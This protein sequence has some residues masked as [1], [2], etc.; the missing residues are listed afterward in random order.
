[1]SANGWVVQFG[2][3]SR[4]HLVC[5]SAPLTISFSGFV[6]SV[7]SVIDFS[8]GKS[9]RYA[10]E[11]WPIIPEFGRFAV[12]RRCRSSERCGNLANRSA[13]ARIFCRT[14]RRKRGNCAPS[15][16]RRIHRSHP[17]RHLLTN[18]RRSSY[19]TNQATYAPSSLCEE[20][21]NAHCCTTRY[22]LQLDGIRRD[23]RQLP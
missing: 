17:N 10:A 4:I 7:M 9:A 22:R 5:R 21:L 6:R 18:R 13:R 14:C 12:V 1:M 20:R 15:R 23:D 11:A 19:K 8:S 3:A 16:R 2:A